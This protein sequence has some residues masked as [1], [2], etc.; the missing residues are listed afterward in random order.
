MSNNCK[1]ILNIRRKL[2]Q[3]QK[4]AIKKGLHSDFIVN[5]NIYSNFGNGTLFQK[6]RTKVLL[7]IGVLVVS[8][9]FGSFAIQIVLSSRCLM[10]LNFVLWEATRPLADCG[11]CA[12]VTQPIIMRNVSR[13][14]FKV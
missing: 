12:N 7:I 14:G 2:K 10:S 3:I 8:I 1:E 13:Q 4:K 6:F 9:V 11:Y 5:H